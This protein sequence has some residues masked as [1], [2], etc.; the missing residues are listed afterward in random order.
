MG[1]NLRSKTNEQIAREVIALRD[2]IRWSACR[3]LDH[4]EVRQLL[5]ET[6]NRLRQIRLP[7]E[8][9]AKHE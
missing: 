9:E 5:S 4:N 1:T 7:L 6:A 2:E 8:N 3:G